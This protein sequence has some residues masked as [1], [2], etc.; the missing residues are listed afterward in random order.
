MIY[1]VQAGEN[2]PIKIGHA[3]RVHLRIDSLQTG[4]PDEL[5]LI[6]AVDLN[7]ETEWDMHRLFKNSHIRGEWYKRT[8]K[9]LGFIENL[10]VDN[11][12]RLNRRASDRRK[13]DRRILR[14]TDE[15]QKYKTLFF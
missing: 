9:L 2:G 3:N 13:S 4:C 14:D 12:R 6:R 8:D 7:H 15:I 1:F 10:C 11:R 5:I